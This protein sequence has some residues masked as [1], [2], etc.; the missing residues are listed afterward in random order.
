M[1]I[2]CSWCGGKI[3]LFD[4]NYTRKEVG[5]EEHFICSKCSQLIADVKNGTATFEEIR[6]EKTSVDLFN[7]L[8]E[9]VQPLVGNVQAE[10]TRGIEQST[11][12]DRN[13]RNQKQLY[14]DIHQ[15][16]CDIRF[17][18]N[19]LIFCIVASIIFFVVLLLT[20]F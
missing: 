10:V 19:Y 13:V 5:N 7:C 9:Q 18:K 20:M 1:S 12:N 16:A 17:L 4:V 3:G 14:E 8:T 11:N 2:K 15:I 6:R